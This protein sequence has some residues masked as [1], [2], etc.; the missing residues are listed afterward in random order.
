MFKLKTPFNNAKTA[1]EFNFNSIHLN[2]KNK[3]IAHAKKKTR[4]SI[5]QLI[6]I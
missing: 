6:G 5:S 2:Y 4:N 1:S 3:N